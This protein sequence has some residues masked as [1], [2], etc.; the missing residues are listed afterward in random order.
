MMAALVVAFGAGTAMAK[1]PA[2]ASHTADVD[3]DGHEDQIVVD[4]DGQVKVIFGSQREISL[5]SMGQ[6][7]ASATIEVGQGDGYGGRVVVLVTADHR[8]AAVFAIRRHRSERLWHGKVGPADSDGEVALH[9]ALSRYGLIRYAT[10]PE[11]VRCDGRPVRLDLSRFDFSRGK[12]RPA[13]EPAHIPASAPTIIAQPVQ[14][15][16]PASPPE[17][18]NLASPD[19]ATAPAAAFYAAATSSQLGVASA[20][21][22]SAPVEIGDG[23]PGTA[24]IEGRNGYGRGEVVTFKSALGKVEVTAIRIIPGDASSPAAFRERNRIRKL[25]LLVGDEAYWVKLAGD[26]AAHPPATP[27]VA[28]LPAPV[29][30]ACVSAVVREVYPGRGGRSGR[31][32][33]AIAELAVLTGVEL[34][35]GGAY[36]GLAAKVAAGGRGYRRAATVLAEGGAAAAAAVTAALGGADV[37]AGARRRLVAALAGIRDPA[38]APALARALGDPATA[39]KLRRVLARALAAIG[40]PAV[41][42]VAEIL[43]AEKAPAAG[44]RVAAEILAAIP[45][46]EAQSALIDACGRGPRSLRRDL[47]RSL[48]SRDPGELGALIAAA[49][50]ATAKSAAA[51]TAAEKNPAAHGPAPRVGQAKADFAAVNPSADG[52]PAKTAAAKNPAAHGPAPRVGQA[53]ADFAAVN[54][55]A[56]IAAGREA[57]LWRAVGILAARAEPGPRHAAAEAITRRLA[58]ARGYELSYRLI[59]AAAAIAAP[60]AVRRALVHPALSGAPGPDRAA[61]AAA[62]RRVAAA[63]L[64][65]NPA[66]GAGPL[67]V[68]LS[69]DI[70]PGVRAAATASLAGR[71]P[72][73]AAADPALIARLGD[74]WPSV[75]RAAAAALGPRCRRPKP[76][77]ALTRAVT[78]DAAAEVRRTALGSLVT[79]R[80]AGVGALLLATTAATDQPLSVRTHAAHL[81]AILGDHNLV[82]AIAGHLTDLRRR[83]FS[84]D[85]AAKVAAALAATLG[86][87][88]DPRA[89]TALIAAA[90]DPAF[91]QI[92]AAAALALGQL[93]VAGTHDLLVDL[94]ASTQRQVKLAASAALARC[95]QP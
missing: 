5:G 51:K 15:R 83:A 9:V 4:G 87:L 81:L 59:A 21:G 68:A 65:K 49:E 94:A 30:A 34:A 89:A 73:D 45:G 33:T 3:G 95:R 48:G 7:V 38:A 36:P 90:R 52:G 91:P 80:A 61:H 16:K 66:A 88:D 27:Y 42:P 17:A 70:D 44:R 71:A 85:G 86:A 92:Q 56:D 41:A 55:S 32:D 13:S 67:L 8:Q 84:E 50:T 77:A 69:A 22:L 74:L 24:W 23:D 76:A 28:T 82:I 64:A 57:D 12:F 25:A 39:A 79:C 18:G 47:A 14:A 6:K 75:R 19:A 11:V 40:P 63:H 2:V 10:R 31:G 26:P 54:P 62:L 35:P 93:C 1:A 72:H 60:P 29:S 20:R 53:K 58:S 78:T 46:N 43:A 37:P